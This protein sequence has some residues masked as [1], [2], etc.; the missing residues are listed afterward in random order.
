MSNKT[1]V[2]EISKK[3]QIITD[4]MNI[5]YLT[6]KV[7]NIHKDNKM[8]YIS[9]KFIKQRN[10]NDNNYKVDIEAYCKN[11]NI[12][13][14]P[15]IKAK[16]NDKMI[17]GLGGQSVL[18]K[19]ITLHHI[20]GIPY[21]PGQA[22]KGVFRFCLDQILEDINERSK[23][24]DLYY[25]LFGEPYNGI[26]NDNEDINKQS[27]K[28]YFFDAFPNENYTL[29]TDIFNNHYTSYYNDQ[30]SYPDGSEEP[31][32]NKFLVLKNTEFNIL[33]GLKN[34][35]ELSRIKR[36]EYKITIVNLLSKAL[37]FIGLG[38]KTS[39][40][41][42]YFTI[43][44]NNIVEQINMNNQKDVFEEKTN[45]MT[46]TQKNIYK[47]FF[48]EDDNKINN[49]FKENIEKLQGE[50]LK[51][52]A[53]CMKEYMNKNKKWENPNNKNSIKKEKIIKILEK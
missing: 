43:D 37:E 45:H 49:F 14:I 42:G 46:A 39:V 18:E 10:I 7:F 2:D 22:I 6:E 53:I 38:A 48:E 11:M 33:I 27:G 34:N 16:M 24:S 28:I 19:S 51:F 13:L 32:P 29:H 8:D 21:I 40:G 9:D 47:I 5:R 44:L 17:I 15:E 50:N 20:Y 25:Y 35:N 36:L 4:D 26:N 41:Y 30:S 23:Y 3:F 52:L 31:I 12:D 1:V